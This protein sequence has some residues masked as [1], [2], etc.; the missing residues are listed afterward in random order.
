MRNVVFTF[1][2]GAA[3]AS[4]A[5]AGDAVVRLDDPAA[6]D[7]LRTT[8]P[9]HYAR[10]VKILASANHLCRPGQGE[11]QHTDREATDLSC[12]PSLLRTSNPPKHEVR[13]RMDG[14]LYVGL[15]ALTDDPARL[16]AA[17][18]GH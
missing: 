14:K 4:G 7:H 2:L 16:M 18:G 8:D 11:I 6:M 15:V 5:M 13:F 9:T 17:N 12:A 1:V 3:V 10:V